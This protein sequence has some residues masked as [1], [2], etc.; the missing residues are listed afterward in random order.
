MTSYFNFVNLESEPKS[1]F[2]ST[3][4]T[5][6][7]IKVVLLEL[8]LYFSCYFLKPIHFSALHTVVSP[9]C[10]AVF[11]V[12]SRKTSNCD[13]VPMASVSHVC[14][15]VHFFAVLLPSSL[16]SHCRAES[17]PLTAKV[18][19]CEEEIVASFGNLA[20]MKTE[21]NGAARFCG[22]VRFST[23]ALFADANCKKT[24]SIVLHYPIFYFLSWFKRIEFSRF[25]NILYN[26]SNH[27][28]KE[29]I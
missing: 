18:N 28:L 17:Q 10:S 19:G 16:C 15:V 12:Y 29:N 20:G 3:C 6:W 21:L 11:M 2:I 5:D 14:I 7:Q 9:R 1:S 13:V 23:S 25:E 27:T 8:W 24:R 4:G 26:S 22:K